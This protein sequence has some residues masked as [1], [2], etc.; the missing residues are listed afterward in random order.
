MPVPRI[1]FVCTANL[2]RSPAA[3]ALLRKH[4]GDA[5]H[6]SSMG[7][8][9]LP[10]QPPADDAIGMCRTLDV[11]ISRHRS[12]PI[13]PA[14]L[15]QAGLILVMEPAQKEYLVT[16]LPALAPRI[17]LAGSWPG[18]DKARDAVA[19]PVGKPPAAYAALGRCLQR[20]VVRIAAGITA[21]GR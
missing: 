18:P 16:V 3:E 2:C 1:V 12:R 6:V 17:A 21:M 14:E 8:F 7:I 5:V 20:H 15:L 11:D 4:M 10:G 13:A 19:D 9:A